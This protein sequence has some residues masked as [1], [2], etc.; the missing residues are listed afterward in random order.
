MFLKIDKKNE[1]IDYIYEKHNNN[2]NNNHIE[3]KFEK[4]L[5]INIKNYIV[6]NIKI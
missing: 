4:N 2:N 1:N 6:I 5:N 3:E